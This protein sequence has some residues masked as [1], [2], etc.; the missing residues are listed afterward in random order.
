[1]FC[2]QFLADCYYLAESS[3]EL[4]YYSLLL[5]IRNIYYFLL[6]TPTL[7]DPL[8]IIIVAGY[9]EKEV[10]W[11]STQYCVM[12]CVTLFVVVTPARATTSIK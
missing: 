6:S 2:E 10:D 11:G 5:V 1:M 3:E 8:G 12:L 9:D 7:S 4:K